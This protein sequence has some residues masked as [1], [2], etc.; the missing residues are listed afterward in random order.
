[1]IS[2]RFRAITHKTK[3]LSANRE[4]VEA[5]RSFMRSWAEQLVSDLSVYPPELPNQSYRRTGRLFAAWTISGPK[6]G[7]Q[8]FLVTIRNDVV[9][10][11]GEHYAPLVHGPIQRPI[12]RNRWPLFESEFILQ[13]KEF[14]RVV[15]QIMRFYA[16]NV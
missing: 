8:G 13:R 9:D 6:L 15:R 16:K 14:N 10:P 11:E 12:H 4:L 7:R 1:M 2:T 5:T 3:V